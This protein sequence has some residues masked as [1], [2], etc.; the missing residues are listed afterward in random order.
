MSS[1]K[2]EDKNINQLEPLFGE[3]PLLKGED[4]ARYMKLRAAVEAELQPK[5][6]LERMNVH[7]QT[8]KLWEEQRLRRYAAALRDGAFMEALQSLL[9]PICEGTIEIAATVALDYYSTDPK[10][11]KSIMAQLA[12]YGITIEMI[13][14]KAMQITCSGLLMFDRM[15]GNREAS[16]RLLRKE[17]ERRSEF[18]DNAVASPSVVP[19]HVPTN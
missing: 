19:K 7:D 1:E 17:L 12:Q 14:A 9:E 11:K 16:R 3:P 5:T 4:K 18:P 8:N 2:P 6:F 15:I 13:E 10:E